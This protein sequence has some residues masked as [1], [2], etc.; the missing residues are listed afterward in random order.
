GL[1]ARL[2]HELRTPITVVRTSLEQI[3]GDADGEPWLARA[4]E[5]VSRLGLIVT[6][7]G[8]A[9]RLEQALQ[10]SERVEVAVVDLLSR[11]VEGW[12]LAYS[13]VELRLSVPGA[14]LRARLAP[15]LFEQMMEKLLAN[16]VDFHE[17][18]TPIG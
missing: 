4:R 5:G 3:P 13:G 12:R 10:Q 11:C 15:D 14:P 8:E 9:A 1:A 17:P 16:A 18:G 2:T 7:L 6:R